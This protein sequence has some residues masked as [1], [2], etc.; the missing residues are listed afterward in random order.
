[1]PLQYGHILYNRIHWASWGITAKGGSSY[2]VLAGNEIFDCSEVGVS[3][4][5]GTGGPPS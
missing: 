1:M 5:Q 2:F 3:V 4:G